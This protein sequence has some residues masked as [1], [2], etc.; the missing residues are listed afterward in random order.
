VN[1][2]ARNATVDARDNFG[3][4]PLNRAVQIGAVDISKALLRTGC[5]PVSRDQSGISLVHHAAAGGFVEVLGLLLSK[6]I[7]PNTGDF[8]RMPFP[9][10]TWEHGRDKTACGSPLHIAAEYGQASAVSY[11]ID[12]GAEVDMEGPKGETA[13]HR[14]SMAEQ[15]TVVS[16]LLQAH[17]D[18]G[19]HAGG[20][21]EFPLTLATINN[22]RDIVSLLS[23]VSWSAKVQKRARGWYF[24]SKSPILSAIRAAA[25]KDKVSLMELILAQAPASFNVQHSLDMELFKEAFTSGHIAVAEKLIDLKFDLSEPMVT[26]GD[27]PTALGHAVKGGHMAMIKFLLG[28]KVNP[29]E[30]QPTKLPKRDSGYDFKLFWGAALTAL[31][32]AAFQGSLEVIELLAKR[33]ESPPD[34]EKPQLSW[35]FIIDKTKLMLRLRFFSEVRL[36]I[37]DDVRNGIVP[38]WK[39]SPAYVP[40]PQSQLCAAIVSNDLHAVEIQIMEGSDVNALDWAFEPPLMKAARA[41][42]TEIVTRLLEAGADVKFICLDGTMA[43]S[44]V[45]KACHTT[46]VSQLLCAGASIEGISLTDAL[47]RYDEHDL[48]L[49]KILLKAGVDPNFSRHGEFDGPPL[50]L[51]ADNRNTELIKAALPLLLGAGADVKGAKMPSS[52]FTSCNKGRSS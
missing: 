16:I 9:E 52:T 15:E 20:G 44:L 29:A 13:R 49:L 36:S 32:R 27:C 45:S 34:P 14:A 18:P 6:N 40:E 43:L 25:E 8:H 42:N 3:R 39:V 33:Q 46:L 2:L 30:F 41:A 50:C 11:L 4:T 7:D 21:F 19:I 17:A 28:R 26:F 12:H 10:T 48:D 23:A 51:L 47:Q 5:N 31:D 38:S 22:H 24:K 35:P 37:P 1:L